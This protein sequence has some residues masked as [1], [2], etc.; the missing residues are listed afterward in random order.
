MTSLALYVYIFVYVVIV[1]LGH[2]V[3]LVVSHCCVFVT[4]VWR[5]AF[6]WPWGNFI[7]ADVSPCVYF[8][9]RCSSQLPP[10]LLQPQ[11][12]HTEPEQASAA[13]PP[14]QPRPHHQGECHLRYISAVIRYFRQFSDLIA[15]VVQH[16]E[17]CVIYPVNTSWSCFQGHEIIKCWP[18]KSKN[19][20]FYVKS[21]HLTRYIFFALMTSDWFIILSVIQNTNN[22]L[23]CSV[24]N[25]ERERRGLFGVESNATLPADWKHHG[26][27]KDS[28][29]SGWLST[30]WFTFRISYVIHLEQTLVQI[31]LQ[32]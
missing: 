32:Q 15:T 3:V 25:M 13:T 16:R 2:N 28:G 8:A 20:S 27:R 12:P 1:V 26:P 23:F 18:S 9:H 19:F 5:D 22:Q 24:K 6:Y 4:R 10:L 7:A 14:Q 11:L 29:P 17:K 31:D 21:L 30:V